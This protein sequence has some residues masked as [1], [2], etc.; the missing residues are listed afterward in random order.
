MRVAIVSA[1]RSPI[2]SFGGSL[3]D[4]SAS[5]LGSYVT[6]YAL[7]KINLDKNSISEVIFGNVLSGGLGQNVARQIAIKSGLPNST[8]AYSVNKVCASGLKSVTLGAS[9]ILAKENEIVICGGVEVMSRAPYLD[10][11]SRFGKKLGDF[12]LQDSLIVDGLTDAFNNYHMGITAENV[13][14]KYNISR[15]M[16]DEFA[17]NSQQKAKNA[18][19]NNKFKEEIVPIEL[20]T[21][22]EKIIFSTDE[23]PRETT[24]EKL[25]SLKPAFLK[26]GSVTAGN[27]S[28]I[29]DGSAVVILMSEEKAREL[30]ITPLAFIEGYCNVA[31]NPETMGES[32]I[33]AIK[34]LLDKQNMTLN[35]IALFE[36]NEAFAS[37][38]IA[39]I[40][41]LNIDEKKVNV[42]GGAIALGHPIGCSGTRILVSLIHELK[43]QNKKYGLCSLCVGGGQSMAMIISNNLKGEN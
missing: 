6:K 22:K 26:D 33:Y 37:Q 32:P 30:N 24:L 8:P 38:S 17:L 23:Y 2:G 15:T 13:A 25:S 18:L 12:T 1:Y 16:Q 21:K 31:S 36:L 34:K 35:D 9:S 4:I 3:K 5:D 29:N 40:N 27:S 39:I 42:N 11:S 14:K 20:K 43:K 28:G 41:E 7:E 10:N 19:C